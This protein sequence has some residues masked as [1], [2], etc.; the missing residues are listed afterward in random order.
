MME[1]ILEIIKKCGY[2]IVMGILVISIA[3]ASVALTGCEKEDES[4]DDSKTESASSQSIPEFSKEPKTTD[5]AENGEYIAYYYE[6]VTS[7]QVSEYVVLLERELN[8]SFKSE[9]YPK[10]AVYGE[11]LI[12][13]HYNVTEK[14]LSVT[15]AEKEYNENSKNNIGE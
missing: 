4:R 6:D 9:I 15:I 14:K 8:I 11:K 13:I 10:T 7:E 2:T 1:K 3:M 12:A 5:K